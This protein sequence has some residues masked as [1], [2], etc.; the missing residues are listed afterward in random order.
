MS[1]IE[2][3]NIVRNIVSDIENRNIVRNNNYTYLHNEG[4]IK[5]TNLCGTCDV[6]RVS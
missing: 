1:D 2:N 6:V 5:T 4:M 3:R